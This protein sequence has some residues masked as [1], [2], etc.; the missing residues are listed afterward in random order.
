MSKQAP[1]LARAKI[2][3]VIRRGQAVE[4]LAGEPWIFFAGIAFGIGGLAF[5]IKGLV[6]L[7]GSVRKH[8]ELLEQCDDSCKKLALLH[9]NFNQF[10]NSLFKGTSLILL[11]LINLDIAAGKISSSRIGLI[12][13]LLS[14]IIH[15]F[16]LWQRRKIKKEFGF[17]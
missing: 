17:K 11:A 4:N 6:D 2:K 15:F 3:S 9:A 5:M 10:T 14:A 13:F 8:R 16:H 12:L 7:G 1:A